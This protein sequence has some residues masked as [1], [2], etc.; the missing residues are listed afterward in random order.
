MEVILERRRVGAQAAVS[1]TFNKTQVLI[2]P[3]VTQQLYRN[4]LIILKKPL[5]TEMIAIQEIN[6]Y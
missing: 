6:A 3:V 5:D 4:F 2:N 1:K